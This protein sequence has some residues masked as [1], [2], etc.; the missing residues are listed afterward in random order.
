MATCTETDGDPKPH[1]KPPVYSSQDLLSLIEREVVSSFQVGSP[2][3][4]K[5]D[6]IDFSVPGLLVVERRLLVIG[7]SG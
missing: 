4:A 5:L 7:N 2:I 6:N 3:V 1:Q